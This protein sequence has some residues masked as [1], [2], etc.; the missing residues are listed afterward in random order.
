MSDDARVPVAVRWLARYAVMTVAAALCV[1]LVAG[2]R[3]LTLVLTGLI[4]IAAVLAG[5]WWFISRRGP[6]RW[7]GATLAVAA[8][9]AAVVI[10]V[11][12]DLLWAALGLAVLSATGVAAARA[13]SRRVTADEAPSPVPVAPPQHPVL[14]MNPRS[15]GGKVGRFALDSKA[16]ALGADVVLLDGDHFVDVAEL[17]RDAIADD[18]D[19]LGVAGGDGTQAL[20][21]GICAE[22]DVA[23]TVISAGTRNHFAM[24]LGLDRERP[25]TGLRALTD[26]AQ[27]RVDLGDINGRA[28]VNNASFG[29][30]AAVVQSPAYR[31]D[32]RGTTLKMLPDLLSGH[33]GPSLTVRIDG[34]TVIENLQALLVGNNPYEFSDLAGLGHRARLDTGMLGVIV[35]NVANATEAIGLVRGATSRSVRRMLAHEV[36]IESDADQIPVGVDG[37]ALMLDVPVRCTIRPGALRVVVPREGRRTYRPA[38]RVELRTLLREAAGLR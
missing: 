31:D 37:E 13:A 27:M 20:V 22:H 2:G 38:G 36:V 5:G 32:K 15:G 3:S 11:T 34:T 19:L 17:A 12:Q 18:A 4:A 26:G 6:L 8:P 9:V 24:D 35:V 21:A 30:Y 14:I 25:E 1:V 23:F 10:Y 29:V 28:F 7:F 16:E 33:T